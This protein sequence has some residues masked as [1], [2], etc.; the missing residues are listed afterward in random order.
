MVS[1]FVLVNCHFPFN[2]RIMDEISKMPSVANVYRISGRYDLIVKVNA[3]TEDEV[4]EIVSRDI[5]ALQGVDATVTIIIA[6]QHMK[7]SDKVV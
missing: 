6:K 5:S 7:S 4:K 3:N 1:A 2:T